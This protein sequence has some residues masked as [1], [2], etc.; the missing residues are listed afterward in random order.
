MQID[1]QSWIATLEE[2]DVPSGS[3]P[4]TGLYDG[5]YLYTYA[6]GTQANVS[7]ALCGG[8]LI[9]PSLSPDIMHIWLVQEILQTG[10]SIAFALQS[11]ITLLNSMT[12]YDNLGNFDRSDSVQ[13]TFFILANIPQSFTGFTVVTAVLC[14]H[15]IL[16]IVAIYFFL[17]HTQFSR[18]GATWAALSQVVNGEVHAYLESE[19]VLDDDG[20]KK[21]M[22]K[23]G[24]AKDLVGAK[25]LGGKVGL[26]IRKEKA[27]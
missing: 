3:Y 12:Y 18:L 20:V 7:G 23:N 10:G 1:N 17:M 19:V 16:M 4:Q 14:V 15:F 13:Q 5:S 24:S 25:M 2:L 22:E 6:F 8:G 21:N 9:G 27:Q 26:F 11:L